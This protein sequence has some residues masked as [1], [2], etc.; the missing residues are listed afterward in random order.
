MA[1]PINAVTQVIPIESVT[2]R[3][4]PDAAEDTA[5]IV[6]PIK[7]EV[8]IINI[9]NS[10]DVKETTILNAE[11]DKKKSPKIKKE[12]TSSEKTKEPKEHK[13]PKEKKEPKTSKEKK[14]KKSK[15]ESNEK[16]VQISDSNEIVPR[17][18]TLSKRFYVKQ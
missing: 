12:K 2:I 13:Q 3:I 7:S 17:E 6:A 9:S 8:P 5:E 14:E 4:V 18:P 1:I 16:S 15:K 10:P 11:K